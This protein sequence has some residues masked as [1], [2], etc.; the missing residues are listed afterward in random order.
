MQI[1]Y[2]IELNPQQVELLGSFTRFHDV[3]PRE[4]EFGSHVPLEKIR[5]LREEWSIIPPEEEFHISPERRGYLDVSDPRGD[6]SITNNLKH[7]GWSVQKVLRLVRECYGILAIGA[8]QK[9]RNKKFNIDLYY[10]C[11]FVPKSNY[12]PL[13]LALE[14]EGVFRKSVEERDLAILRALYERHQELK[15]KYGV[16]APRFHVTEIANIS[17]RD[18]KTTRKGLER[19]LGLTTLIDVVPHHFRRN[20]LPDMWILPNARIP[21]VEEVLKQIP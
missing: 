1:E 11:Y 9:I 4:D 19:L 6:A 8:Q 16:N 18:D 13:V 3:R 21:Q 15:H 10:C 7:L 14:G 20:A 12:Q 17:G 2:E 5:R